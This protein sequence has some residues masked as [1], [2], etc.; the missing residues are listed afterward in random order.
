MNKYFVYISESSITISPNPNSEELL[1]ESDAYLSHV[2]LAK[3]W[4]QAM[5]YHYDING[6]GK[7]KVMD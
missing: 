3:D 6:W 4:N 2:I 7:Y 1:L 5:Q